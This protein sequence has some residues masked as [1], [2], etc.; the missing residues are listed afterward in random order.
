MTNV[1]TKRDDD[2]DEMMTSFLCVALHRQST[3]NSSCS[4]S[5]LI[6]LL[7][8]LQLKFVGETF[9]FKYVSLLTTYYYYYSS[10]VPSRYYA[11]VTSMWFASSIRN[12]I[13]CTSLKLYCYH[14]YH[15]RRKLYHCCFETGCL[16]S[17]MVVAS[18]L[19]NKITA[20][21]P[22]VALMMTYFI[23]ALLWS[24]R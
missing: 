21:D 23:E 10:D 4:M 15:R 11:I 20:A 14:S 1:T 12:F 9:D 3:V 24:C 6:L 2:M 22:L 17:F 13:K 7:L 19:T 16:E 5:T 18:T 8:L